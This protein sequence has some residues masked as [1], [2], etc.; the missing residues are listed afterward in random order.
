MLELTFAAGIA[1]LGL[2]VAAS[3]WVRANAADLRR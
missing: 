2:M 3:A 1:C